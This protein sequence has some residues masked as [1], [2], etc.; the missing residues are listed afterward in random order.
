MAGFDEDGYDADG[1]DADGFGQDGYDR[2]G[3]DADGYDDNGHD[4]E[5]YT[6]TRDRFAPEEGPNPYASEEEYEE[7]QQQQQQVRLAG[8]L[9]DGLVP[10]AGQMAGRVHAYAVGRELL[11]LVKANGI[12][13]PA[14]ADTIIRAAQVMSS[15]QP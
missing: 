13:V 6:R 4:V 15:Q 1:F 5:G 2:D 7:E 12:F 11:L 10:S 9:A 3:Y 8:L 14:R